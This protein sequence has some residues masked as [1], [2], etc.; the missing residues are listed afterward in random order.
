MSLVNTPTRIASTVVSTSCTSLDYLIV[1]DTFT[2]FTFDNF[3]FFFSDHFSQIINFNL[4]V[5]NKTLKPETKK[6]TLRTINQETINEFMTRFNT[7][8]TI[9]NTL[10]CININDIYDDF[11]KSVLWC[12][13]VS[14]PLREKK[15]LSNNTKIKFSY[16]LHKRLDDL[17]GL[18]WLRKNSSCVLFHDQYNQL[19]KDTDKLIKIEK[20]QHINN[21][22][23]NSVNKS[24]TL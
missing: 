20:Q 10:D 1:S 7:N 13:D 8:Y 18:N 3:D 19:K 2:D 6:I 5:P 9:F 22:L 23:E 15:V 14:C 4:N 17:K 11:M 16:D 24:K 12:F 21:I